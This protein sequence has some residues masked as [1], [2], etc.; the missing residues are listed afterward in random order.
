MIK[1]FLARIRARKENMNQ[2][3][4][5]DRI[6]EKIQTKKLSADE[7]EL[8]GYM[9]ED[10]KAEVKKKLG[11]Y[12]KKKQDDFWHHDVISQPNMHMLNTSTNMMGKSMFLSGGNFLHK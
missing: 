8:I 7:R 12:R 6:S 9:E 10:R 4:E 11:E 2:A 1:E 5:M 3:E